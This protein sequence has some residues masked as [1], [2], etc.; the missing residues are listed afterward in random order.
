MLIKN[1]PQS[2]HS[3]NQAKYFLYTHESM[4]PS[5]NHTLLTTT[6]SSIW[7][8]DYMT[9]CHLASGD[10]YSS[11]KFDFRVPHNTMSLSVREVCQ[12]II[13]EYKDE[14]IQCHTTVAEWRAISEEFGRRWNMPHACAAL[15][16]KHIFVFGLHVIVYVGIS[17]I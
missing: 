7:Q 13:D 10:S 4:K 9:L 17:L 2:F 5:K 16:G 3:G 12:A 1:F 14:C 6:R 15:D 11:M 8:L